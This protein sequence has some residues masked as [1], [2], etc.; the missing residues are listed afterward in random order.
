MISCK[1]QKGITATVTQFIFQN[2]GN[3]IHADQHID[4][5]S[6]TFF[7]RV[8]WSLDGFKLKRPQIPPA[9]AK[10]AETFHMSWKL[11]FSDEKARVAI[12][13]GKHLH[14]LHDLLYR[15][16]TGQLPCDIVLL[17]SNHPDARPAAYDL[18]IKFVEFYIDAK[19]KAEQEKQQIE[20]LKSAHIDLIVL[21]RYHQILTK[22]FVDLYPQQIIN[23]HHSF[24]PAFAGSNPYLQAYQ[25]GV[26]VIGATSHYVTQNLDEGPILVQQ[27]VPV[28]HRDSLED[29]KR[30]GEDLEKSVLYE[31]VRL[32]LEQKILCYGHKTVVFE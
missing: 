2:Q 31:A 10:I 23:I 11:S 26:K 6:N 9:F 12:F 3:I 30:K 29:M 25:K 15:Y 5:Q 14:C 21:A 4:E 17:I 27:T 1:D 32:H 7:M 13:A 28:T 24:L 22:A 16:K 8:E 20:L 18:D 19:N